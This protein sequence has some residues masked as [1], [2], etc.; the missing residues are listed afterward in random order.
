[1]DTPH[2]V[3]YNF[4]RDGRIFMQS[5]GWE[6]ILTDAKAKEAWTNIFLGWADNP[7]SYDYPSDEDDGSGDGSGGSETGSAV[8][9][10][11]HEEGDD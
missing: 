1:M 4:I 2:P 5:G 9:E 10:D 8:D 6:G 3:Y 7:D 11:E